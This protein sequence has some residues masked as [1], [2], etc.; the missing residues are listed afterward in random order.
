MT[1]KN[2]FFKNHDFESFSFLLLMKNYS[3]NT[4]SYLILCYNGK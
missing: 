2:R 4:M 3:K 1:Q